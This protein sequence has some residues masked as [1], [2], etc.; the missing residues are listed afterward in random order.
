MRL[1]GLNTRTG[2]HT[3]DDSGNTGVTVGRASPKA[4]RMTPGE[5]DGHLIAAQPTYGVSCVTDAYR[6]GSRNEMVAESPDLPTA[7]R[8]RRRKP[9][10]S[11]RKP[12]GRLPCSRMQKALE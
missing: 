9:P 8:F 6:Q 1:P 11:E 5:G 12:S 10:H 7:E 2:G 3:N 4:E